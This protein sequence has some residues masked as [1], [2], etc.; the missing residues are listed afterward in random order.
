MTRRCGF[1]LNVFGLRLPDYLA[2]EFFPENPDSDICVGHHEVIEAAK[3]A[4]K[5]GKFNIWLLVIN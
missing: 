5:P 2:C 1:F 3:R 4:E